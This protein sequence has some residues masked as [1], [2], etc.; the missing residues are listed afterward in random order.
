[1]ISLQTAGL[2]AVAAFL[3]VV[4]PGPNMLL[5]LSISAAK[6][7]RDGLLTLVGVQIANYSHAALAGLGISG[8]VLHVPYGFETL[9][10][11]GAL[12]LLWLA[13]GAWRSPSVFNAE[14][15]VGG[16]GAG[17][18]IRQGFLT[19]MLNPKVILFFLALFPQFIDPDRGSVLMQSL[20]LVTIHAFC[21]VAVLSAVALSAARMRHSLLRQPA[22]ARHLNRVLAGVFAALALRLLTAPRG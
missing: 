11:F 20:E 5:I 14:V 8:L 22:I 19:N 10:L 17:S 21:G 13:W 18:L 1:M 15:G 3:L 6:G 9:K 2:F 16:G 12:Y 4:T 7:A